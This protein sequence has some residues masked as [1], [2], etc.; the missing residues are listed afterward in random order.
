M[1]LADDAEL[2]RRYA[3][4][5]AEE[6]FAELV[7]RHLN[8]VYAAALRRVGGDAH[9]AQDVA[10]HVF[11]ALARNAQ[12]LFQRPAL[13]GWLYT[14]TRFAAAQVVRGERRRHAREQEAHTM[15]ASDPESNADWVRLRPLLDGAMD[16]LGDRDREAVLL[17]FFEGR[18]FANIGAALR[19]TEDAARMRVERALDKLHARLARRGVTSTTAALALALAHQTG[20]AAPATFAS[21]VIS[22]AL[23]GAAM[24]TA[25]GSA[26]A[27]F[28]TF[29]GAGKTLAGIGGAAAV[30]AGG[31]AVVEHNHAREVEVALASAEQQQHAARAEIAAM[32]ARIAQT[33]RRAAEADKDNGELLRAVEALQAQQA[34][35]AARDARTAVAAVQASEEEQRLAQER[36]YQQELAKRRVEEARARAK[37]ESEVAD[38]K[39]AAARYDKL[40]EAAEH[41]AA[42]AEFQAAMRLYNQAIQTKPTDL[43]LSDRVKQ[44]RATLVAQNTPMEVALASDGLTWVSIVNFRSPQQF[45]T[46]LVK[47]LPGNYAVVGRRTGY[48]DVVTPMQVRNGG[49]APMIS[50]ACTVPVSP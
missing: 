31:V 46:V 15:H 30:L 37:I 45:S 40:I 3:Q 26:A 12:A 11:T 43:A 23:A 19:L 41:Y 42:N 33:E 13:A 39:D 4:N 16:A 21:S 36:I 38:E 10:Q 14:T 6:A 2:L 7:R 20:V 9:L 49:P 48:Q 17:R 29:L 24:G 32:T 22:A 50:V 28:L 25:G 47:I 35:Q 34:A 44:L 27:G 1:T 8:L 5:G 18:S